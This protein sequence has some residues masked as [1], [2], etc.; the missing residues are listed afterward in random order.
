MDDLNPLDKFRACIGTFTLRVKRWKQNTFGYLKNRKESLICEIEVV[1]DRIMKDYR[2]NLTRDLEVESK[3]SDDLHAILKQKETMW[4][5]KAKVNWLQL[6]NENTRF[7]HTMTTIRKKRNEIVRVN[8]NWKIGEGLE[9]V[10][11]PLAWRIL[12]TRPILLTLALLELLKP[13][14]LMV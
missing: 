13:R 1:Q 14:A 3:L 8:D 12:R 10:F 4:A 9:Q 7:F 2:Y 11:V 6:G 5:Q